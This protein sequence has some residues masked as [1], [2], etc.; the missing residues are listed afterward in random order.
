VLAVGQTWPVTVMG[1]HEMA[2]GQGLRWSGVRS[3]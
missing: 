2:I 1:S 3:V